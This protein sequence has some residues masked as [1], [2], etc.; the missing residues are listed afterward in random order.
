MN[1]ATPIFI[2]SIGQDDEKNERDLKELE[3]QY[4]NA[5]FHIDDI[6]RFEE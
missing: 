1:V 6:G 2:D 3:K 4:P 5:D